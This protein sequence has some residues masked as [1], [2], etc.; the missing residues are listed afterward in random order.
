MS[1]HAYHAPLPRRVQSRPLTVG[2]VYQL[3]LFASDAREP[4]GSRVQ[5]FSDGLGN[6]SPSFTQNTFTSIVG[7]F[8]ADAE[9]QDLGL[10]AEPGSDPILEA[11][12]LRLVPQPSTLPLASFGHLS[13]L[14][15]CRPGR[16]WVE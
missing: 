15:F 12:V 3:Q 6:N 16:R 11:Y 7:T 13:L 1:F 14:G 5:Y 9:T 2:R 10:F 4:W 8:E